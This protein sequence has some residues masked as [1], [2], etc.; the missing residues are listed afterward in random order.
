MGKFD[1]LIE[2]LDLSGGIPDGFVESLRA[3]HEEDLS[4]PIAKIDELTASTTEYVSQL[5]AKDA[6][7]SKAK[8]ANYDLLMR[9]PGETTKDLTPDT[10]SGSSIT[11]N[12]LFGED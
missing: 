7:I 4:V 10:E 11:P 9:M 12:D 6:E 3:A 1:D 8:A 5:A 2:S